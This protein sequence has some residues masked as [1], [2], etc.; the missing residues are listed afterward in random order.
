MDRHKAHN[1]RLSFSFNQ[2][3]SIMTDSSSSCSPLIKSIDAQSNND[4]TL[5]DIDLGDHVVKKV[6]PAPIALVHRNQITKRRE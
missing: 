4:I 6:M 3:W 5:R 2:L 1:V